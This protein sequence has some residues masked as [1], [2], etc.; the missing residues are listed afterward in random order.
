MKTP[1]DLSTPLGTVCAEDGVFDIVTATSQ[2]VTSDIGN[3]QSY[4]SSIETS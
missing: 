1:R 3:F 2:L 4:M